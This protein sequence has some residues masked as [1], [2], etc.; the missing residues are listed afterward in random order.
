MQCLFRPILPLLKF[1]VLKL[2]RISPPLLPQVVVLLTWCTFR[3]IC[4]HLHSFFIFFLFSSSL[5]SLLIFH[6]FGDIVHLMS[7]LCFTECFLNLSP[8]WNTSKSTSH[9][10]LIHEVWTGLAFLS[11]SRWCWCYW[12]GDHTLRTAGLWHLLK[13]DSLAPDLLNSPWRVQESLMMRLVWDT[14]LFFEIT[15]DW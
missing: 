11:I 2:I 3:S 6:L 5:S 12:L 13:T 7:T 14:N 8:W 15:W 9:L 1:C 10:G 4:F